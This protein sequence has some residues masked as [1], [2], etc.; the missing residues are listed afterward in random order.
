MQLKEFLYESLL[1][2]YLAFLNSSEYEIM[3]AE[4]EKKSLK[5]I[6][7]PYIWPKNISVHRCSTNIPQIDLPLT[8][9]GVCQ[10]FDGKIDVAWNTAPAS[11]K[12]L[13]AL[14]H[15]LLLP[16][17]HL[18]SN[19]LHS[20][21]FSIRDIS[22]M[23][24]GS[25][26]MCLQRAELASDSTS[27]IR[28]AFI[29]STKPYVDKAR[30][31]I[32]QAAKVLHSSAVLELE[33][34][35]NLVCDCLGSEH[36]LTS[37]PNP[38]DMRDVDS[39]I[40]LSVSPSV[41][42]DVMLACLSER[43][44]VIISSHASK[45]VAFTES[46]FI[47]CA[48]LQWCHLYFPYLPL[49]YTDILQ[50]PV[51]YLVGILKCDFTYLLNREVATQD[52]FTVDID[53]DR[54]LTGD[55]KE[56]LHKKTAENLV[57][58]LRENISHSSKYHDNLGN[59]YDVGSN[60]DVLTVQVWVT[61]CQRFVKRFLDVVQFFSLKISMKSI[62]LELNTICDPNHEGKTLVNAP[63]EDDEDLV[64]VDEKL[65]RLFFMKSSN[66]RMEG[67]TEYDAGF[68][69]EFLRTQALSNYISKLRV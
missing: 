14:P 32:L 31:Y 53:E 20:F 13:E 19:S 35:L 41:F 39:T 27:A 2:Y 18:C 65:C 63:T 47:C 17:A 48:P 60:T 56:T 67:F 38:T 36:N 34:L 58:E 57:R 64:L 68:V 7:H 40:I 8:V 24:Y 62:V 9:V 11:E 30:Q 49:T 55:L 1:N 6:D 46:L 22:S 52:I 54:I 4:L 28:G 37:G 15:F 45:L 42:V 10:M 50:S 51:P 3:L 69:M 61:T 44:I 12:L 29:L 26:L 5:E 25:S 66:H 43:K 21:A 33:Q 23:L 59:T 16:K